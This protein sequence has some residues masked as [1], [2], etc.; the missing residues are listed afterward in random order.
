MTIPYTIDAVD[1]LEQDLLL[2]LAFIVST[3]TGDLATVS[4]FNQ[5]ISIVEPDASI[6]DPKAFVLPPPSRALNHPL[7]VF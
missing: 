5:T 7:T 4:A 6:F 3:Q 1:L 2:N